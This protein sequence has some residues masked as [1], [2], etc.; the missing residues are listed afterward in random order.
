MAEGRATVL[1]FP[2]PARIIRRRF[3]RI[4][5]QRLCQPR[6]RGDDQRDSIIVDWRRLLSNGTRLSF[7]ETPEAGWTF[8]GWNHDVSGSANPASLNVSDE[9][10]VTADYST[11]AA[12]VTVTS[13]SPAAAV[14]GGPNFTLTINGKRVCSRQPGVCSTI[15]S[16]PATFVTSNKLTVAM[17]SADLAA[18][19]GQQVF[20]ENFPAALAVRPLLRCRSMCASA[21]VVRPTPQTVAFGAQPVSTT[22]AVKE[23]QRQEYEHYSGDGEFDYPERRLCYL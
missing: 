23:R 14:S 12:P 3:R 18:A 2:R 11:T 10:F 22:S 21:P 15:F 9:I 7:S 6:L 13:L 16:A 8:T 4:L 1:Q 19:G 5:P 17:T 20:V